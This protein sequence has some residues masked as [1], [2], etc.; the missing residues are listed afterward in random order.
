[1]ASS[2]L[3]ELSVEILDVL[4][5]LLDVNTV[6]RL[7]MTCRSFLQSLRVLT[8]LRCKR[9]CFTTYLYPTVASYRMQAAVPT[10][11]RQLYAAFSSLKYL[12][13]E[14]CRGEGASSSLRALKSDNQEYESDTTATFLIR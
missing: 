4:E 3:V 5:R 6:V 12:R 2:P 8:E 7:S 11:W 13:W 10:T 1:M 9:E 14:V